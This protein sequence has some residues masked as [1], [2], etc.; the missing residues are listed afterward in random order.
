MP[1]YEFEDCSVL[2]VEDDL[3]VALDLESVLGDAG[4]SVIGLVP[5]VDRALSKISNNHIDV[6]LLDVKL[7]EE[8]VM[9]VADRLSADGIPFIFI[10]AEPGRLPERHWMRPVITKPYRPAT[11]LKALAAVMSPG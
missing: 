10:T 7:G 9:A 2:I 11:V 6:A 3:L 8:L 1:G 5:S 4:C